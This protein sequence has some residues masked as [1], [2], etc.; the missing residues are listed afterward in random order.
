MEQS[1]ITSSYIRPKQHLSMLSHR[2]VAGLMATSEEFYK[3]FR[4]CVLAV[5][6]S[7][8]V[9]DDG[10]GL[11][12][13][14]KDFQLR[15]IQ[16][17]RGIKMEVYNAPASAFVN[18]AMIQGVQDHVF[19]ALRDVI[20][21][22][23]DQKEFLQSACDCSED[24][25]EAV[26]RILRNADVVRSN[27]APNIAV[28][29][30]GHAIS[31]EE[32]DFTKSV[33]Y[34]MGLRGLNIATG[35][36]V[37]AMKGPMKGASVGHAKQKI[38]TSRFIGIT[39]P[40]IIAAEPPNGIV[41]ELVILPDIEKR[42]EAFVRLAHCIVVFPGGP[43]TAEEILYVLSILMQAENQEQ[44][45]PLIFACDKEHRAYFDSMDKFLRHCLGEEVARFYTIIDSGAEQVAET[46]RQ[47]IQKV[48]RF[49]LRTQESYSYNWQ[50]H[51]PYELQQP[52]KP[53]HDAMAGL[54]LYQNTP[55]DQLCIN[56]RAA[57]SGIVA[58]NVKSY[59]I[60]QIKT[61]GPY[62]LHADDYIGLELSK[63]LN[64]FVEQGRMSLSPG[65]VPSFEIVS[66]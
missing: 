63:L 22:Q 7:G 10:E 31:R 17:S 61:H 40:G 45:L 21:W 8:V 53:T 39:E 9:T 32:Y 28:C 50:L 29:W 24:I 34:H 56:L 4:Q 1:I 48:Q 64:D 44:V 13:Q 59:G 30:G 11:V 25:T 66:R 42:L 65:Y 43:G 41:N 47:E 37:G 2:E 55:R 14:Y 19:S 18:G 36:G 12:K 51:I 6:N 58:G 49:R 33:G 38:S 46:V 26:F 5:L 35:C 3:L 27:E 20:Y 23:H 52:F 57:F 54:E 60:E 16:Q 62:Q 15:L